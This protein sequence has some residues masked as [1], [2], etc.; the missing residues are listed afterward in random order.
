MH[1]VL[2][3]ERRGDANEGLGCGMEHL[4]VYVYCRGFSRTSVAASESGVNSLD[5]FTEEEQMFRETGRY[6]MGYS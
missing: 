1:D 6:W 2:H 4:R 3:T 5:T